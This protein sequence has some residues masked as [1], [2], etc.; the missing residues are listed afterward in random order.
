M[1]DAP[2]ETD[3]FDHPIRDGAMLL[4]TDERESCD[5]LVE[6]SQRLRDVDSGHVE[7]VLWDPTHSR[8]EQYHQDDVDSLF[9]DTGL[10]N[11]EVKPIHDD[12][13]QARY[14]QVCSHSFTTVH[15]HDSNEIGEECIDCW[16]PEDV[17]A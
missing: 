8:V 6:V 7:Y 5:P 14:Q 13:I 16:K 3:S 9:A 4:L 2:E 1:T 17:T 11:T 15:D 12:G 10:T